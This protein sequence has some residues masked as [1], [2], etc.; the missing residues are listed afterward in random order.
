MYGIGVYLDQN[1]TA[2]FE[3]HHWAVGSHACSHTGDD[4]LKFVPCDLV[5]VVLV[6]QVFLFEEKS[7]HGCHLNR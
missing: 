5:E 2:P 1:L 3:K 7:A 4:H 6:V